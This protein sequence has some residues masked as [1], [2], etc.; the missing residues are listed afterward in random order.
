MRSLIFLL[1]FSSQTFAA[2]SIRDLDD[3]W[4]N[5]HVK[6]KFCFQKS[7]NLPLYNV[8]GTLHLYN[9]TSK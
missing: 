5:G 6:F 2:L 7:N 3:D 9:I 8:L 4:S 1:L